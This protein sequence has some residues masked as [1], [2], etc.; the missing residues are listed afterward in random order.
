MISISI[1]IKKHFSITKIKSPLNTEFNITN[2]QDIT[3]AML[4]LY[5]NILNDKIFI[6]FLSSK[7]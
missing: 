7:L 5:F 6:Q 2:R 4:C 1:I 3:K